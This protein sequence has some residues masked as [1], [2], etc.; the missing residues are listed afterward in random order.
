MA[1]LL[2]SPVSLPTALHAALVLCWIGACIGIVM[3][4]ILPG[5]GAYGFA[6]AQAGR[7]AAAAG[8]RPAPVI[9]LLSD[10]L[11]AQVIPKS[12]FIWFYLC[13]LGASGLVWLASLPA[14]PD[15]C[16]LLWVAHLLRRVVE[17]VALHRWRSF[18]SWLVFLG[19][20]GHYLFA[21]GTIAMSALAEPA[22]AMVW[23]VPQPMASWMASLALPPTAST[24]RHAWTQCMLVAAWL[25]ASVVQVHVHWTQARHRQ[26][27]AAKPSPR[28]LPASWEFGWACCP[29]YTAEIVL[30]WALAGLCGLSW[31]AIGMACFVTGNL[32]VSAAR[33][34]AA[35]RAQGA[36][37]P[38]WAVVP[39]LV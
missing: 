28:R 4:V 12:W 16:W 9:S 26:P 8:R 24:S 33:T 6:A 18:M 30:Y 19:G 17:C 29:H 35:Y 15:I 36:W 3:A 14:V 2:A 13:G 31:A 34:A 23:S 37:T 21:T 39:G 25:A 1:E 10:R 38:R 20:V 32:A 5:F 27:D 7:P 22:T 11:N